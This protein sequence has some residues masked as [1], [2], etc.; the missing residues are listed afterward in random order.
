MPSTTTIATTKRPS[1]PRASS[2]IVASTS[3]M[4]GNPQSPP[5]LTWWLRQSTVQLRRILRAME[6]GVNSR[7]L[8][9]K[10]VIHRIGESTK[11]DLAIVLLDARVHFRTL[12]NPLHAGIHLHGKFHSQS[13]LALLV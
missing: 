3:F 7:H 5:D 9:S 11:P 2:I 1:S 6:D 4:I 13:L 12:A 10:F 8:I